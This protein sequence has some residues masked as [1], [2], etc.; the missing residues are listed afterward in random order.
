MPP[1][2][3]AALDRRRV[4]NKTPARS[5]DLSL[6]YLGFGF[7]E[8]GLLLAELGLVGF[9]IR[10][11]LDDVRVGLQFHPLQSHLC[12]VD[13]AFPARRSCVFDV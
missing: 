12:L 10:L 8:L 7:S 6:R 1:V 13:V 9:Q 11:G 3:P 4:D 5:Y 2:P